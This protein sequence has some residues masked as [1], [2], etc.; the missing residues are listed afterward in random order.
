MKAGLLAASL[1]FLLACG[2]GEPTAR[3]DEVGAAPPAEAAAAAE[4]AAADPAIEFERV[5]AARLRAVIAASGTIAARRMTEVAAEVPGRI[6]EVLVEVGDTVQKDQPLFRIDPG[7]YE[8]ALAEAEAGLALARAQS[9]NAEQEAKRLAVLLERNAASQQRYE[10]LRTQA[11]VA[12]A[13]VAQGRARVSRA[14]R[15]LARTEVMAPYDA[16]V[17]ERRAHEG[18]MAGPSPIVV[19]QEAGAFEAILNVPEATPVAVRPGD[20]VRLFVE[21]VADPLR[22]KIERVSNRVDPGTRTY[23]VRGSVTDPSGLLKAGS[24]ARAELLSTRLEERPVVHSSSLL[25]RDGRSYVLR[26]EDGV[27]HHARVRV[28]VKDGERVEI[29]SGAE[30]GDLVVRGEATNRL[31][32]GTRIDVDA[33]REGA[34]AAATQP[35]T[36]S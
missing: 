32:D 28:G 23:E 6:V 21:G 30:A 1:L 5:R 14:R 16:S 26:V 20:P 24:Y 4:S 17:V 13:Q 36:A 19:L 11:A 35:E 34:R 9:E 2:A 10:Q 8:M 31:A 18:A 25:T 33:R 7:P 22:T 27:I 15:D 3:Q 29:L 12:R